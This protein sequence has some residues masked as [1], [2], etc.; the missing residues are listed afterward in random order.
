MPVWQVR[1]YR[2]FGDDR[3]DRLGWSN[4]KLE[5]KIGAV[6]PAARVVKTAGL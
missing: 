3:R 1:R 4:P 5:W 2:R 6:I